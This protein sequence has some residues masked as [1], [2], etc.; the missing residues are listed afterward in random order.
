MKVWADFFYCLDE[1]HADDPMRGDY[2]ALL[3]RN[4]VAVGEPTRWEGYWTASPELKKRL[5]AEW[6]LWKQGRN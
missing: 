3:H 2:T 1:M 4:F 5:N 6:I